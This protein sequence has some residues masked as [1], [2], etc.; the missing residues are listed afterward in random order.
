MA[1]LKMKGFRL[2]AMRRDRKRILEFLQYKGV[3]EIKESGFACGAFSKVDTRGDYIYCLKNSERAAMAVKALEERY[4]MQ[5]PAL[6]FLEGR[7]PVPPETIETAAE[8]AGLLMQSAERILVLVD[9]INDARVKITQ[10]KTR[11]AILASWEVLPVCETFRG[12][13][14]TAAFIGSLSGEYTEQAVLDLIGGGF[15]PIYA[16][17]IY[18]SPEQ[19]NLFIIAPRAMEADLEKR[20]VAIGFTRPAS[21]EQDKSP[22]E[23][24]RDLERM[25]KKL[26][27]SI[28]EMESDIGKLAVHA[29]EL[30]LTEDYYAIRAEKYRVINRLAQSKHTF[31]L[32]GFV[33]DRDAPA[34]KQALEENFTLSFDVFG[35]EDEDAPVYLEN[36]KYIR[37]LSGILESYSMPGPGE[38]DPLPVMSVFY[39]LL[40]GLMFSDAG[41]GLILVGVCGFLLWKYKNMDENWK[42]NLRMFLMCGVSTVFWGIVFSSYFGDVVNVISSIFIGREVG[43]PP[44]WFAPLEKPMLLLIF[45]LGLGIIHLTAGYLLKARHLLA[46]KRPLDAVFDA[47]FP[48]L[49]LYPLV[50]IFMGSGM[51]NDM[52]GFRLSVPERLSDGLMWLSV[53]SMAGI[54]LTAG[55]ES[56]GAARYISGLYGLYNTLAGWLADTLSYSRLLALGLATSVIASVMNQ[57]GSMAGGGVLGFILFILVFIVG[58]SMNLG[59][60][61][62][63]AYVHSNRL[64]YVEFFGK[65]YEGGGRK[66]Q[67]FSVHTKHIKIEE[68]VRNG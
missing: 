55:R 21:P 56:K 35:V 68:A 27:D 22:G 14:H 23:H 39:Y 28:T 65:F 6:A 52:A 67:P 62:L 57:L 43:I 26:E 8:N 31:I 18:T 1:V 54:A 53:L 49:I 47:F 45:C 58:Q 41:Y 61:V 44:L 13:A 24:K 50:F 60:N 64:A 3:A 42:D 16:E 33:P 17:I 10:Y 4:Q 63:G 32:E 36:A 25:R 7:K 11:E 15:D 5:K 48:L 30:K 66:F 59:I 38:F 40:F 34:L 20:L 51:F 46:H 2:A 9:E 37:A 19:T 12:T 29:H